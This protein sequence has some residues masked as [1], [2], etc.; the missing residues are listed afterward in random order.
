MD[1]R[2]PGRS[3]TVNSR[4]AQSDTS[5]PPGPTTL[6]RHVVNL[7]DG[8]LPGRLDGTRACWMK[9]G[10]DGSVS[11]RPIWSVTWNTSMSQPPSEE[12]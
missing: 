3:C 2:R 10:S 4:A 12:M 11:L 9:S 6:P 1:D 5:G 7:G 8:P